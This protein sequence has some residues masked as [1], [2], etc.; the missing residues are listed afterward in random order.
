M[1]FLVDEDLSP[2]IAAKLPS[3][4]LS[5]RAAL[6]HLESKGLADLTNLVVEVHTL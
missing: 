5:R 6:A 2:T 1:K 3:V 4:S